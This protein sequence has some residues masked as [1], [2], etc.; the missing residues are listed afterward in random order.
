MDTIFKIMFV[1]CGLSFRAQSVNDGKVEIDQI[2]PDGLP[3]F[4]GYA[5]VMG[6]LGSCAI[7]ALDTARAL[8]GAANELGITEINGWTVR[9]DS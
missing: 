4:L 8:Q 5:D 6:G 2:N 7:T 1:Y 9:N 3:I